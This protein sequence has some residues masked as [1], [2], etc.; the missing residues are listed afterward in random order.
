MP[1]AG[2][3]AEAD[4]RCDKMALSGAPDGAL[5]RALLYMVY[6]RLVFHPF[7]VAVSRGFC[8]E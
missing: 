5:A 4:R 1:N 2:R 3:A 6:A 7:T 8:H